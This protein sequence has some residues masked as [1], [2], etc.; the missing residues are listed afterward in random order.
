MND[1]GPLDPHD[2][3]LPLDEKKPIDWRVV[4]TA[5]LVS[6]VIGALPALVAAFSFSAANCET[7]KSQRVNSN[8]VRAAQVNSLEAD[9]KNLEQ[10]NKLLKASEANAKK[11]GVSEER[12][13][14]LTDTIAAKE[15]AIK[16]KE[17][18]IK[19]LNPLPVN[20]EE[21]PKKK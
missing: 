17:D 21:L 19:T 4:I 10:D 12:L 14:P 1:S 20:C 13:K 3:N 11:N 7:V 18:L 8:E 5:A 16:S 15:D 9:I 2:Y 6:L